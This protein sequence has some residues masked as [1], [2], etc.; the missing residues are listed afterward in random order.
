MDPADSTLPDVE[1][2]LPLDRYVP[3]DA[4]FGKPYVD[5]DEPRTHPIPHRYLHGGFSGTETKFSFYLPPPER[6]AGRF[7]QY[8]DPAAGGNEKSA[9]SDGLWGLSWVD[10]LAEIEQIF[11]LGGVLTESNQGHAGDLAGLN[12]DFSI[13]DWRANA[14]TGRFAR[15]LVAEWYSRPARYGY[16]FGGCA[17]GFRCL[18]AMAEAPN[19]WDGALAW[20]IP[21]QSQGLLFSQQSNALRTLSRKVPALNPIL[22]EGLSEKALEILDDA[23]AHALKLLMQCGFPRRAQLTNDQHARYWAFVSGSFGMRDPTYARDFWSKPGYA[24]HGGGLAFEQDLL[25]LQC[26]VTRVLTSAD[27][28]A[29]PRGLGQDLFG[30]GEGIRVTASL[31]MIPAD[32]PM[33]LEL[34]ADDLSKAG[35]ALITVLT[36]EA[37]GRLNG[38]LAVIDRV[39]VASPWAKMFEGVAVGDEVSI[40]NTG[41][42]SW[43][44][45]HRH[46]R[47]RSRP[48]WNVIDG[49]PVYPQRRP[50][51][52][53]SMSFEYN[54][55]FAPDAKVILMQ[56]MA[57]TSAYPINAAEFRDGLEK[58]T[59]RPLDNF[60]RLWFLENSSHFP[61]SMSGDIGASPPPTTRFIEFQGCIH[62]AL[63][64]LVGWTEDGR[65]PPD[66]SRYEVTEDLAVK[67]ADQAS[68]RSGL[69]PLVRI[70]Q[71][72]LV[73]LVV[74]PH[75]P[76][77]VE[78]EVEVPPGCGYI[79]SCEWSDEG[80]GSWSQSE[81]IPQLT[82]LA[83]S[84]REI[85]FDRPGTYFPAVRVKTH[86]Q[87]DANAS[88]RLVANLARIRVEVSSETG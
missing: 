73:P 51:T 67:L 57:D 7:F 33:A 44:F 38:V 71:A 25:K 24:G 68:E 54:Y 65:A 70:R 84:R 87:G 76:L 69:Q 17:G 31:D 78:A 37:T 48:L 22:E 55:D 30:I 59:A 86:R 53:N 28:R 32:K 2:P 8:L 82:T 6:F 50:M 5:I 43:C 45:Y 52:A 4:F 75:E 41:F 3:A 42:L 88:G 81:P 23:E 14:E 10:H 15:W 63:D 13:M 39:V 47:N 58:A 83:T 9:H 1:R 60:F 18:K 74:A 27:V 79:V 46:H 85:A 12:G 11:Q 64:D 19:V 34:N 20:H 77:L 72:G 40:D 80:N 35:C 36:G 66:T 26:R 62:Q 56:S 21:P 16:I 49:A 61:G 29:L